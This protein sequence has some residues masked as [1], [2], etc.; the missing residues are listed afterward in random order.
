MGTGIWILANS[1]PFEGLVL[2]ICILLALLRSSLK[3]S[4][5]ENRATRRAILLP[6][7]LCLLCMTLQI[8]YYNYRITGSP[9]TLPYMAHERT[10]GATP[11]LV[12]QAP[13]A[14]VSYNHP[15]IERF[16]HTNDSRQYY[17]LR[18]LA[19]FLS[20]NQM[21]LAV[22]LD[23]FYGSLNMVLILGVLPLLLRKSPDARL[24]TATLACVLCAF[25]FEK[26]HFIHYMAPAMSLF[27][28]LLYACLQEITRWKW[29]G[30][31]F[32]KPFAALWIASLLVIGGHALVTL[33]FADAEP[34]PFRR[35]Q[36]VQE[37]K[38]KGGKHLVLVHYGEAHDLNAEWVYNEA[39]I[40][41]SPIVWA[42]EMGQERDIPLLEHF[43]NRQ[44]WTLNADDFSAPLTPFSLVK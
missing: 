42:E 43:R 32:G 4:A 20:F 25:L 37:L 39:D 21:K 40:E 14:P 38:A 12:W 44:L 16:Y 36:I 3:S 31:A 5:S 33:P 27:L 15:R 26:S 18:T 13:P 1:R 8:G 28:Y 41:N 22:V 6:S 35:S 10:Y 19:G 2:T 34:F 29:Q 7:V 11:Q 30:V 24:A 9:L 17:L 23:G